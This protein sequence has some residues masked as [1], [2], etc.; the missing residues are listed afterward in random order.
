[1]FLFCPKR[2]GIKSSGKV[3]ALE[4]REAIYAKQSSNEPAYV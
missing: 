1:M 2:D 4:K 3:H